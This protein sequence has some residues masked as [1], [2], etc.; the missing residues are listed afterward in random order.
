MPAGFTADAL[1]QAAFSTQV[2]NVSPPARTQRGVFLLY[3]EKRLPVDEAK[4]KMELPGFLAYLRQARQGDAF[5]QWF[6]VQVRQDPAFAAV[7]QRT[8]EES[9]MRSSSRRAK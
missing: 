2:G 3:V 6:S 8:S 4:L 1:R 5:N 7:L 9:Q